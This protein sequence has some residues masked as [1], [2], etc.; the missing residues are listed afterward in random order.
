[1]SENSKKLK[2]TAQADGFKLHVLFWTELNP[3]LFII[4]HD[5]KKRHNILT[6][7]KVEQAKIDRLF[8]EKLPKWLNI[9]KTVLLIN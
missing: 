3:K 8:L 4:I 2:I 6:S 7:E 9:I 1:M 5:F